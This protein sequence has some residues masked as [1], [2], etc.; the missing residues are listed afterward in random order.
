MDSP[1]AKFS[2]LDKAVAHFKTKTGLAKALDVE[3]MTVTHWYRRGLPVARAKQISI[4]TNGAVTIRE[5]L[6]EL[7]EENQPTT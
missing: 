4:A 6:P 3:P 5:L 7:F 2:G 1:L